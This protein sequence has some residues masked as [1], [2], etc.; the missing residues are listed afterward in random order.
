MNRDWVET[1]RIVGTRYSTLP[2]KKRSQRSSRPP[3]QAF[4]PSESGIR[5]S[6][7]RGHRGTQGHG[8][9]G[10]SNRGGGS[11]SHGRCWRCNGRGHFRE[12]RDF[13]AKR[14][15]CSGFG[16]E[17]SA[18]SSDAAVLAIELPMTEEDFAVEAQAFVGN[19][20]GKFDYCCFT[21]P[22]YCPCN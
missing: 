14:A 7:R 13:L 20:T 3:E 21:R 22:A 19:E 10:N 8:R 6:A 9:D 16:H 5:R 18:S 11:I 17:E 12:E 2:Q 4:F 15:R 1:I